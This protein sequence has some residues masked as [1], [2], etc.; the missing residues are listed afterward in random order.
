MKTS[1]EI[2]KGLEACNDR[3]R[4]CSDCPYFEGG[5]FCGMDLRDDALAYIRQ[6]ESK[7][8]EMNGCDAHV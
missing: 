4:T 6:L 8:S 2:K 5:S 7:I 1:D 3:T